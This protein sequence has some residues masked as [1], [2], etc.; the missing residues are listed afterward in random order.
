MEEHVM[1]KILVVDDSPTARMHLTN[2]LDSKG[3]HIS[4]ASDG[5][6]ALQKAAQERPD[7][8]LLDVVMPGANGFQVCRQ[9]K[10]DAATKDIKV[11]LV[12]S[13]NQKS[14][15]FWGLKQGADA[16]ITKPFEDAELLQSVASYL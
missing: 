9:L 16:Y 13:K 3:Y 15:R 14:D 7:L 2:L 1:K 12:T 5:E 11:I 10:A 8:I 4:T 6:E